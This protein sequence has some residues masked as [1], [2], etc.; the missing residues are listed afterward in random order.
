[1]LNVHKKW[2]ICK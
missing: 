2:N 1:M